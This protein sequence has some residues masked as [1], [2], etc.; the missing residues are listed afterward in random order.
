MENTEKQIKKNIEY[1]T[2]YI[3]NS[4]IDPVLK[5]NMNKTKKDMSSINNKLIRTEKHYFKIIN[6]LTQKNEF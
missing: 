1:I 2:S 5:K 3:E 6:Q 4:E